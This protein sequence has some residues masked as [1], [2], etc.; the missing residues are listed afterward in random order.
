M[1]SLHKSPY[2]QMTKQKTG[3]KKNPNFSIEQVLFNSINS[4][5]P[6]V[7]TYPQILLQIFLIT[8]ITKHSNTNLKLSSIAS[9]DGIQ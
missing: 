3:C 4:M 5:F 9:K 1:Y 8:E 2:Q 6:L 7:L